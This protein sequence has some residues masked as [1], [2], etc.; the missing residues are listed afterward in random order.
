MFQRNISTR[1]DPQ[2]FQNPISKKVHLKDSRKIPIR[3]I[4]KSLENLLKCFQETSTQRDP[5]NFSKT[6]LTRISKNLEIS[7]SKKTLSPSLFFQAKSQR[8][9]EKEEGQNEHVHNRAFGNG[10]HV[11]RHVPQ[12][13]QADRAQDGRP[14]LEDHS[15]RRH[16]V[17]GGPLQ[18]GVPQRSG[19]QDAH[20]SSK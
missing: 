15:G 18:A 8:D 7:N 13:R 17:H 14:T 16:L 3:L 11:P 2:N 4:K 9:R 10:A 19:A 20:T 5:Q 1:K 6:R 12:T